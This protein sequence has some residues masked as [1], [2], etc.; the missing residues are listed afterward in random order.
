MG[1]PF[2]IP[3]LPPRAAYCSRANI[4]EAYPTAQGYDVDRVLNEI[5]IVDTRLSQDDLDRIASTSPR[6]ELAELFEIKDM[7]MS[8]KTGDALCSVSIFDLKPQRPNPTKDW[9]VYLNGLKDWIDF[10]RLELPNQKL[11]VY[12]G[13]SVWDILHQ[14]KVLEAKDVDF[15]RMWYPSQKAAIGMLWRYMAFDDYDFEYVYIEDLDDRGA[16]VDNKWQSVERSK[17]DLKDLKKRTSDMHV[18]TALTFVYK[19][20]HFFWEPEKD[21]ISFFQWVDMP[22]HDPVFIH[23]LSYFCRTCANTVTRGPRRLPFKNI[24]P[25]LCNFLQREDSRIIYHPPT[26]QWSAFRETSANIGYN[27][28]DEHYLFHL[29]KVINIKYWIPVEKLSIARRIMRRY[30]EDCLLARLYQQLIDE[31]NRLVIE[32]NEEAGFLF[33]ALEG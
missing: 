15:V 17:A 29:T 9:T 26:N 6:S 11:R 19:E 28:M 23:R 5:Q 21:D 14:E 10:I 16:Y 7:Q 1:R 27:E 33:S 2:F 3:Q 13:D 4:V 24:I 25:I 20:E 12:V 30:G 31:G 32:D 18:G 22:S 8:A